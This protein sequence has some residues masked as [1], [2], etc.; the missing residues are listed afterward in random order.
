MGS[1]THTHTHTLTQ[2]QTH[3]HTHTSSAILIIFYVKQRLESETKKISLQE[4]T[5]FHRMHHH[6][7]HFAPHP[8]QLIRPKGRQSRI[9]TSLSL[10]SLS[11]CHS[12]TQISLCTRRFA[13]YLL[14]LHRGIKMVDY[15]NLCI[16]IYPHLLCQHHLKAVIL[17]L[18]FWVFGGL[19]C[20]FCCCCF[21]G[22]IIF[23]FFPF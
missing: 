20:G 9:N 18:L 6:F 15:T 21:L 1:H 14:K 3:T 2:T 16:N 7:S 4:H 19:F 5:T 12:T 23:H 10:P 8:Q 13:K 11:K 22:G 17:L